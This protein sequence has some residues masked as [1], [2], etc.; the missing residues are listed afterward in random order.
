MRFEKNI[1]SCTYCFWNTNV[2][3]KALPSLLVP[4]V[5]VVIVLPP[6]EITVRPVAWPRAAP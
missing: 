3:A 1:K 2:L 5:V 4:L 6:F